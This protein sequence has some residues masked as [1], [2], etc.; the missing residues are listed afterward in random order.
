MKFSI[1]TPCYNSEKTIER[2]LKSVLAQTY[3]NYEYIIIDGGSKDKTL[4]IIKKYETVF[5]EKITVISEPDRGIYDAMNKGI[6]MAKGDLIGIVNSDDFYEADCLE[7]VLT[8]YDTE[9]RYQIIYGMMR[10]VNEY[11]EE[12][13]IVFYHHKNIK[14]QMLNHPATFVSKN[15]YND[16]GKYDL[17][18]KSAADYDYLLKISYEKDILFVPVYKIV[19]NFTRGGMSGSYTGIQEANDVRYKY[20]L[21]SR[22][23]Y[24]LTKTKNAMK[25]FFRI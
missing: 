5:N 7:N 2:T 11:A 9:R 13:S 1:I 10:I 19:T 20:R 15:I 4:D 6:A 25:H 21:V 12:L 8:A 22:K 14:N 18:F 17:S 24:L 23:K 3:T 16:Y